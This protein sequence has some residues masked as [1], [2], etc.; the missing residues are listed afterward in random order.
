M[1]LQE[2]AEKDAKVSTIADTNKLERY[3][4]VSFTNVRS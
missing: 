2:N 3:F 4:S 1:M